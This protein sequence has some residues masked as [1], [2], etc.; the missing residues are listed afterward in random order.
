MVD[1]LR[2]KDEN[3]GRRQQFTD[4]RNLRNDEQFEI[5]RRPHSDLTRDYGNRFGGGI[6]NDFY[7]PRQQQQ[8][9][10]VKMKLNSHNHRE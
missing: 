9:D 10:W 6:N 5:V 1:S 2:Q 3:L 8:Y 4:N 7:R